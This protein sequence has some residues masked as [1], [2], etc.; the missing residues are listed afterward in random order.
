MSFLLFGSL[1]ERG[2]SVLLLLFGS[3]NITE[4]KR[5]GYVF[6]FQ[7]YLLFRINNDGFEFL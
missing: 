5:K 2:R 6:M 4:W 3:Y 1:I 7:F